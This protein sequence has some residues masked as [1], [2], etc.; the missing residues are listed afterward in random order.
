MGK[1]RLDIQGLP[2]VKTAANLF[3]SLCYQNKDNLMAGIICA[4]WDPVNGGSVFSIPIG[5]T[6]VRQPFSIGGE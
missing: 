5:G 4:G 3:R 1:Q 6:L 2:T